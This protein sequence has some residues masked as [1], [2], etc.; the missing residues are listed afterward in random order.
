MHWRSVRSVGLNLTGPD[1]PE[2]AQSISRHNHAVEAHLE[3]SWLVF[4]I[5]EKENGE[6][7][8]YAVPASAVHYVS[9]YPQE[10]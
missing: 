8:E 3:G 6:V 7:H 10:P 1:A 5:Q 9:F 2:I 4:R